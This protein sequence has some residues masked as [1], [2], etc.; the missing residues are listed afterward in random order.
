MAPVA[1]ISAMRTMILNLSIRLH[2][3]ASVKHWPG[4]GIFF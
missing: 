3:I 1:A 4:S 2:M